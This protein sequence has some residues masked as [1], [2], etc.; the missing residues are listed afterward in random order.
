MS[1]V[2]GFDSFNQSVNKTINYNLSQDEQT[3]GGSVLLDTI[4]GDENE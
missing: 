2:V 4:Y 3:I 1:G